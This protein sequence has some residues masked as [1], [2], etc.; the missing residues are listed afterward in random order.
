MQTA[1][2]LQENHSSNRAEIKAKINGI[3]CRCG[4]YLQVIKAIEIAAST[5]LKA[6]IVNA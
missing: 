6:K 2:L 5:I 3:L 4:T 1:S